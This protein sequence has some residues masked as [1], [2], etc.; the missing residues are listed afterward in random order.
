MFLTEK[1]I[2][3]K[4]RSLRLYSIILIPFFLLAIISCDKKESVPFNILGAKI[5]S[6]DLLPNKQ[7]EVGIDQ[8]YQR[9]LSGRNDSVKRSLLLKICGKYYNNG[10]YEKYANSC[11]E[12]YSL[13]SEQNDTLQMANALYYL[14]DYYEAKYKMDSTLYYY[15]Q[16]EKLYR[17]INDTLNS[18]KLQLYKAGILHETGNFFESEV[19]TVKALNQLKN[20]T[21]KRLIYECYLLIA[22]SL[23]DQHNYSKS[24]E[25]FKLAL[26]KIKELEK[27]TPFAVMYSRASCYNNL[28]VLYENK[29][30]YGTAIDFY[31]KALKIENLKK[32]KPV[33]YSML[34]SNLAYS[35]MQLG[36]DKNTKNLL[37]ESLF[38]RDS[39]KNLSGIVSSKIRLGEY[40]LIHKDTLLAVKYLEDGYTLSKEIKSHYDILK[41]L[42]LL[43]QTEK[44]KYYS[45]LYYKISDSL[46]YSERSTRDKFARIAFE[47]DIVENKYQDMIRRNITII[48]VSLSIISLIIGFSI[49]LKYKYKNN[50]LKLIQDQQVA[51]A[52]IYRLMLDQQVKTKEAQLN[53]RNRIAMD[54]HDGIINKIFITRYN[55]IKLNSSQLDLK[56]RLIK[57]L[58]E[59]EEEIRSVSHNLTKYFQ[60]RDINFYTIINE[61]VLSQKNKFSTIFNLFMDKSIDWDSIPPEIKMHLYKIVQELLNNVNKYSEATKCD[62]LF[63]K[64]SDHLNL[65]VADNG[66]GFDVQIF[67]PGIGLKNIEARVKEI[68]GT[69]TIK[70]DDRKG[71]KIQVQF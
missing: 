27:D 12:L 26:E 15:T 10:F 25:Y 20:T 17:N 55:L 19:E 5:D 67:K 16:A 68:K 21:N 18:G 8:N 11:R 36:I 37:D 35:Q 66:K 34:L 46:L 69:L 1:S 38:I 24:L 40:Y 47:T 42:K 65:E 70:S 28:G 59:T 49:V 60:E 57:Q 7:R 31:E 2:F 32:E 56:D 6:V 22:L 39:L 43:S 41:S 71:T 61:L 23:K 51:N 4:K 44:N 53:E 52:E 45:N 54:L 30:D 13:S 48:I 64:V 50:K 3:L 58:E 29:E 62:V 63:F 33:L 9:I 14:G